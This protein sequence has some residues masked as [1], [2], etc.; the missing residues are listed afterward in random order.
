MVSGLALLLFVI[1]SGHG[2][3]HFVNTY[4]TVLVGSLSAA[5]ILGRFVERERRHFSKEVQW[6]NEAH[7]DA[8][9]SLG[10]K[11]A[12]FEYSAPLTAKQST[13][14]ILAIDVD[15]FK[16]V[17]DTYGHDAGDVVLRELASTITTVLPGRARAFRLGGEEFVVIL[18]ETDAD[19]ATEEAERLRKAI[20][21]ASIDTA[22]GTVRITVSIG[23]GDSSKASDLSPVL[24]NADQALYQAKATGRN[25]CIASTARLT[26][27]LSQ[28]NRPFLLKAAG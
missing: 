18:G 15:D 13:Y 25:R 12:F 28:E 3:A 21:A 14:S 16:R 20:E 5:L 19:A 1:P 7:I 2:S 10:N 8:L 17:N 24:S 26:A 22:Q 6:R 11:R 27:A 9:T 23:I 4:P